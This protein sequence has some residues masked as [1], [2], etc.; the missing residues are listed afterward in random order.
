MS[1]TLEIQSLLSRREFA[2]A[3]LRIRALFE[4]NPTN[5]EAHYFKG[6]LHYFRNQV[7]QAVESLRE[8]LK[9]NP[10][11]TDSAICLSVLLNDIGRYD[12]AK[13][14]FEQANQSV[15][16]RRVGEGSEVDRKFAVKHLEIADLY[17]RYRRYDEAI[18]EYTKAALLDPRTL[19]IRI[20]RARAFAKKGFITRAQQDLQQLRAEDPRYLPARLQL[21]LL[22][23]SQ[24]N[25]LDA[26]LEWEECLKLEPSNREA[27]AYLE[28]SRRERTGPRAPGAG[29]A[30]LR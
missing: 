30:L 24:G 19:D 10:K 12:D 2:Q 25:A 6:V 27:L 14:T 26:E 4:K 5:A 17:F 29:P 23:Y 28:M 1:A 11:H 3:E 7:P 16:H 21:G 8:A 15:A 9:H 13:R 20:R 18:E 22:Y